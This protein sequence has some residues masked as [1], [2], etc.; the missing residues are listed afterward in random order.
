MSIDAGYQDNRAI[1]HLY[2][3]SGYYED[4]SNPRMLT[5]PMPYFSDLKDPDEKPKTNCMRSATLS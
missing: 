2:N 1:Y 3:I 5:N 4:L